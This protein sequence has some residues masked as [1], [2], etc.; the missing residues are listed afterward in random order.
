MIRVAVVDDKI[1][2]RKI[3]TDKLSRNNFFILAF[4]AVNGEDFLLQI[5]N[6]PEEDLPHIVLMDLEM[7]EVDGVSAIGTASALYPNVKFVV[8]TIFDDDDK[9]FEAIQAGCSGYLMKD[10]PFAKVHEAIEDI[11]LRNGAPMSPKIAFKTLQLLKNPI[12]ANNNQTQYL[13]P[14][15]TRETE[16]LEG[17]VNGLD[18]K[19]IAENIFISPNTVRN[20]I[21]K[22][23]EK[24]HVSSKVDAVK[25]GMNNKK[26]FGFF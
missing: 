4:Q 16:I 3:I 2:N 10:E 6:L 15:S 7:P 19:K 17:L 26:W 9:I 25:I 20:H 14:L 8:L 13:N 11:V 24:L 23:Y 18:Y 5:R 21:A 12:S 22:I 1:N